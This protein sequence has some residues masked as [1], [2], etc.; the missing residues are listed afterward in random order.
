M[1]E[2]IL[3]LVS[4]GLLD[5]KPRMGAAI[6]EYL[7]FL[8]KVTKDDPDG[9]G[10]FNGLV[11]GGAPFKAEVIARDLGEHVKTVLQNVRK[12]EAEGYIIRKR[13]T[14]NLCSFTVTNSKKWFWRRRIKNAPSDARG[15]ENTPSEGAKP[16]PRGSESTPA[17]KE[18]QDRDTTENKTNGAS[19]PPLP[20]WI[21]A[22]AWEGF[23]EMRKKMR[24]PLT[25]RAVTLVLGKL[26]KLRAQGH[27]PATLLDEAVEHSWKSVYPPKE[28][29]QAL[30]VRYMTGTYDAPAGKER[31]N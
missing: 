23:V 7:W 29:K 27:N 30:P 10:K 2:P 22:D 6:W 17:Y 9:T 21:P 19:A 31:P 12:L 16:I 24:A 26:E 20:D 4:R 11:L 14:G 8:D 18:R 28:H 5:H 15:S 1:S 25:N 13:H 3:F